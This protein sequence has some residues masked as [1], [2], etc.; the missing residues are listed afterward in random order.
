[1]ENPWNQFLAS[2]DRNK[3]IFGAREFD[4]KIGRTFEAAGDRFPDSLL[5]PVKYSPC[6]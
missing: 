1:M 3:S 4:L 6:E 2:L 5:L